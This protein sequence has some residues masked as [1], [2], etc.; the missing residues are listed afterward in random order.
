MDVLGLSQGWDFWGHGLSTGRHM[1]KSSL[2][3]REKPLDGDKVSVTD[4]GSGHIRRHQWPWATGAVR[5]CSQIG[6][7]CPGLLKRYIWQPVE[8]WLFPPK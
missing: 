4:Q 3:V 2:D 6:A 5:T 1:R 8:T 7:P